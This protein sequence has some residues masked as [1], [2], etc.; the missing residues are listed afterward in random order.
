MQQYN[1]KKSLILFLSLSLSMGGT[2]CTLQRMVRTA[3][4]KQE[5]TV[6]PNPL[7]ANG[8]QVIFELKAMVPPILRERER[9][10]IKL[11]FMLYCCIS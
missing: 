6:L 2:S 11:F 4:K 7:A 9:N 3:E 5:V 8:Q 1:K 10:R